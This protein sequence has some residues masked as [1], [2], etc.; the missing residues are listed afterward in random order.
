MIVYLVRR[1][2]W[3]FWPDESATALLLSDPAEDL[4][5]AGHEVKVLTS[6]HLDNCPQAYQS[7]EIFRGKGNLLENLVGLG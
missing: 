6:R 5:A 4:W 1:Y 3:P 7:Q 2:F